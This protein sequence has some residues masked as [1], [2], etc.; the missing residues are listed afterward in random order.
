M[1]LMT[2][3][4]FGFVGCGEDDKFSWKEVSAEPEGDELY[5]RVA[6]LAKSIHDDL[7]VAEDTRCF[8]KRC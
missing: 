7:K 8:T 3:L 6:P 2:G 1:I 5:Q 4:V